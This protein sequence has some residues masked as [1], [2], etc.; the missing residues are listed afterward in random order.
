MRQ[1]IVV[2]YNVYGPAGVTMIERPTIQDLQK[3]EAVLPKRES[4]LDGSGFQCHIL[5]GE[6]GTS[7]T[8]FGELT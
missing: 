7:F 6:S 4:N 3:V 1:M 8:G 2:L 5:P